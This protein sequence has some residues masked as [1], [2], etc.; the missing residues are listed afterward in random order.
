MTLAIFLTVVIAICLWAHS[1]TLL[2]VVLGVAVF[3][4]T[5]FAIA[6]A[7]NKET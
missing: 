3:C 4:V 6:H 7:T 1:F 2:W 5:L